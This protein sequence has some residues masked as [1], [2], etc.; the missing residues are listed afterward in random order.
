MLHSHYVKYQSTYNDFRPMILF[1]A[2]PYFNFKGHL[3]LLRSAFPG[4]RMSTDI[5]YHWVFK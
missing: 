1:H 2:D 4:S 5:Q 3:P